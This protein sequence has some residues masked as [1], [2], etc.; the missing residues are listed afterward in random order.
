VQHID[1]SA[2]PR[3]LHL[4]QVRERD[5][6]QL[7]EWRN[8]DRIRAVSTNDK[9]IGRDAHSKWFDAHFGDMRDRM[10]IVEWNGL[11]AGWYQI[12]GWEPR[13][14]TGGWGYAIGR[15]NGTT[16]LGALL[17]IL[18]LSHAFDRLDAERMSGTVLDT[19]SNVLS[20][21][22]KFGIAISGRSTQ[23]LVRVDGTTTTTTDFRVNR[24]EWPQIWATSQLILPD[25]L[26]LPLLESLAIPIDD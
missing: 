5:R 21:F 1:N 9:V 10:I 2:G 8:S 20:L 24:A 3:A 17:P 26:K 7:W 15:T 12:E 11:D 4:R 13:S 14:R 6:W 16:G 23:P 22:S 25:R 18:G 19:N